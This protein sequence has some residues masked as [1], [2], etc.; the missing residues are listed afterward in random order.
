MVPIKSSDTGAELLGSLIIVGGVVLS[1]Y[2]RKAVQL[3]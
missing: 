1:T 2:Q 3:L